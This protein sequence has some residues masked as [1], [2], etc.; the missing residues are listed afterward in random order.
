MT[1]GLRHRWQVLLR[2]LVASLG[3]YAFASLAATAIALMAP[4]CLGWSRAEGVLT[5]TLLSFVFYLVAVLWVFSVRS[6]LLVSMACLTVVSL[7]W[8]W[9]AGWFCT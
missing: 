4:W 9:S 3:G 7:Q 6:V 8:A 2:V 5:G 1:S